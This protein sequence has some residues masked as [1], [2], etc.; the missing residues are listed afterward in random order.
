LQINTNGILT[1]GLPFANF[2]NSPFPLEIPAIA[3]FYANIDT[4]SKNPSTAI[5][6]YKTKDEDKLFQETSSIRT[7]FYDA[8]DFE[9]VE[10]IGVKWENVGHFKENDEKLNNF[11]V[12]SNGFRLSKQFFLNLIS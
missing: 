11:E 7:S 10:L 8:S 9:A 2:T 5:I 4:S 3:P 1:F 12:F 6:Y